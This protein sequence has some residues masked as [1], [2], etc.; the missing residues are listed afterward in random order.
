MARPANANPDETRRRLLD[1][2]LA[3]FAARGFDGASTRELA[4]AAGVNVATLNYYFGSKQ[5]LYDA[6]VDEVYR[7]LGE[8]VAALFA[9][10]PSPELDLVLGRLYDAARVERD[11]V[12]LLV[13]QVLDHGR[14]T[15]H[16]E[17]KHFLPGVENAARL[18]AGA[19]GVAPATAR[20]AAVT[21]GYLVSRYVIQDDASLA[22]AFGVR[23]ARQAHARAVA[24]LV[25]TARAILS[26]KEQP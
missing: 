23:S 2:A 22:V 25:A 13:R 7:R 16:T 9:E 1:V 8:R 3:Q 11:G 18:L 17:A 24:A 26:T 15:G 4:A 5:G 10:A 12:R 14:L 20:T 6:T 21:I 19:L